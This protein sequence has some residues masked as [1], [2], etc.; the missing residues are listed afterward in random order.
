MTQG[1]QVS[2]ARDRHAAVR[3]SSAGRTGT[4]GRV[5]YL[6][7]GDFEV[8]VPSLLFEPEYYLFDF[9]PE[10]S[11][12]R[13]LVT[14]ERH[15]NLAPFVDIRYE[16]L[17]QARFSIDTGHLFALEDRHAIPRPPVHFIFHHAFV[18]STLLARSLN[19]SDAFFSLKEPWILRRLADF[20]RSPRGPLP[21]SQWRRLF[22][23]YVAL[24]SKNY[25]SGRAA[26]LK[27]TNV[28]NNLLEDV[29]ALLPDSRVV[30]LY[31]DLEAFLVSNLK[32]PPETQRKMPELLADFLR[33][34]DGG[35]RFRGYAGPA[36]GS[37]LR[38][39]AL[40]WASNLH[41]LAQAV[42]RRGDSAVL[43][44]HVDDLLA[45][46]RSALAAVSAHFGHAASPGDLAGMTDATVWQRDA[47]HPDRPY[48][49]DARRREHETLLRVHRDEIRATRAWLEPLVAEL[50]L[51]EFLAQGRQKSAADP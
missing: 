51:T 15:L 19:Q 28:A 39:C 34:G 27:A 2:A 42:V 33:D 13:F 46:P 17:A 29:L 48:D 4:E 45:D 12:S 38:V 5:S 18:C 8:T 3:W 16:P 22:R 47:K 10:A 25:R 32:K 24:L 40:I 49:G 11:I 31:A 1:R 9:A 7:S 50:G 23:G 14:T 44:L 43:L 41:A 6:K 30:Y 36:G 35:T 20:K 21:R 37:L 26:V